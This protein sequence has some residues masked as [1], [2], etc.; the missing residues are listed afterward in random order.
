LPVDNTNVLGKN[1][2]YAHFAEMWQS[3]KTDMPSFSFVDIPLCAV[4]LF[5]KAVCYVL[6]TVCGA[7]GFST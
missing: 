3:H 1:M 2:G 7:G 6:L 4:I 5:G